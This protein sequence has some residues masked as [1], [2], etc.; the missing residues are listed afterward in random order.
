MQ[1][2]MCILSYLIS[3]MTGIWSDNSLYDRYELTENEI[4]FI[5]S[6]VKSMNIE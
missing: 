5:E 4:S 1:H 3:L 6:I 2:E